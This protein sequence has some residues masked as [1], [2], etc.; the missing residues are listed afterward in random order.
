MRV[1]RLPHDDDACGWSALLPPL[2][3]PRRLAGSERVEAAFIGAGFT[4]LAAARR[5]ATVRPQSRLAVLDAQRVGGSASGRNS[6]FIVD[7]PHY[8]AARG[9]EGNR[10]LLRLGRGGMEQLRALVQAHAID[11]DWTEGGRLHGAAGEHGMRALAAFCAGADALGEPYERLDGQALAA[12]TGT[13]YYRAGA[14]TPGSVMVQPAALARGLARTLPANVE[15]FEDSPVRALRTGD[16]FRLESDGG[17]L[18]AERVVVATNGFTP[19]LGLLRDRIFPLMTFA[20]LTRPLTAAESAAVGGLPVWGLVSERPMGTTLR[21]LRDGRL[22]IRNT[23]RYRPSLQSDAQFRR[24]I[25]A[26]HR[27]DFQARFPMLDVELEYTWGGV[28]GATYNGAQF[29]GELAPNL[30]VAAAYNGVGIAMGTI[31]GALL[32]DLALG[33]A[34]P[35]LADMQALPQPEWIPPEP[36]LGVAVRATLAYLARQARGE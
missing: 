8:L 1:R 7:L 19:A 15:L 30:Y 10:R 16:G 4:G 28:M 24:H 18:S 22:L 5:W 31:S 9:L 27:R 33:A 2:P 36:A 21:R 12:L 14:R 17:A 34:S 13:T 26:R 23:V 32:A 20:S 11:C 35:L 29:F 3:A 6:G 25:R